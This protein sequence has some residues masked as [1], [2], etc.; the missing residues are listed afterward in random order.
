M[1]ESPERQR[2]S[3]DT[4]FASYDA[5]GYQLFTA[6]SETLNNQLKLVNTYVYILQAHDQWQMLKRK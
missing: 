4:R 6:L 2:Y 5:D 3:R 1:N